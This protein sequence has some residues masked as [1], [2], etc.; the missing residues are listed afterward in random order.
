MYC[1]CEGA[2]HRSVGNT[3]APDRNDTPMDAWMTNGI[4]AAPTGSNGQTSGV[5]VIAHWHNL[6]THVELDCTARLLSFPRW[7]ALVMFFGYLY[8]ARL[9]MAILSCHHPRTLGSIIMDNCCMRIPAFEQRGC[10]HCCVRLFAIALSSLGCGLCCKTGQ[11]CQSSF[12]LHMALR[13]RHGL[14]MTLV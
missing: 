4:A 14:F 5:R 1:I 12:C 11:H 3:T 8:A 9:H 6:H 7:V 13:Q 10:P 2:T